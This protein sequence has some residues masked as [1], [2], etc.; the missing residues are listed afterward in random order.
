MRD[1]VQKENKRHFDRRRAK[2]LGIVRAASVI[3]VVV[4]QVLFI[5]ALVHWMTT[6]GV[7]VYLAV[8]ILSVL[9]AFGLVNDEEYNQSFWI[10]ILLVLPGFG[11]ILYF[12]W[13][14]RRSDF[15]VNSGLRKREQAMFDRLPHN[16]WQLEEL[17]QVH[18][19][20][21]QISRYLAYE[22]FPV[23]QHTKTKYYPIG[24]EDMVADILNDMRAAKESIL[25]EYFIVYDGSFWQDIEEVLKEKAAEGVDVRIL[26]D[27]F[28]SIFMDPGEM[29][30]V[31]RKSGI[32]VESFKP[33]HKRIS[34]INFNYR[35]HQKIISI[36]GT[37]GYT[38]GCNI[39]DEY[40][41]RIKR[42]GGDEWKDSMVRLE[43]DAVWTLTNIFIMMWE[44]STGKTEENIEK[45]EPKWRSGDTDFV[46]PFS[47]GP[48]KAPYNPVEGAYLRMISKTRDYVYITTP[49]LVLDERLRYS[50]IEAAKSGVDVRITVP[51]IYD[52]W[53]V[54]MVT[55]SNFG[56]LLKNGVR[57]YQYDKGFIHEKDMVSDDEC[58]VCGTINLDF[59]SMHIHHENGV[60]FSRSK[61]V[62]D[63]KKN[64]EDVMEN[65]SEVKYEEWRRRPVL[66]RMMQFFFKIT[67][68]LL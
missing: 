33:I 2:Y 9:V 30:R 56:S 7:K 12:F 64:I 11:F 37:V 61:V 48:H 17:R 68:P 57:I 19:N 15:L 58:A 55:V 34:S 31:L 49:Y 59:R 26:I 22:G 46:Q 29:K 6:D 21:I 23:Y 10:I 1:K 53:Y 36:D 35:N 54:Y 47:G 5:M 40:V 51:K 66:Q 65:S 3:L 32:K 14:S 62:E 50:L 28:G 39:A 13:G 42:Y 8:E 24:N 27:D 43:G 20:K 63:I 38:G 44:D 60:F 45:F 18:P 41:N 67:S 4:L 52:K 16:K 25:L